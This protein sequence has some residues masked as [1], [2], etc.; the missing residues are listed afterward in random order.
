MVLLQFNRMGEELFPAPGRPT[1]PV[2]VGIY[3]TGWCRGGNFDRFGAVHGDDPQLAG[4]SANTK[5][6]FMKL[7]DHLRPI[8]AISTAENRMKQNPDALFRQLIR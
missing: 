8:I 4:A 1:N 7:P 6:G 2:A 3:H 5:V